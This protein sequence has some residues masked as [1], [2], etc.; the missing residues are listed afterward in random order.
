MDQSSPVENYEIDSTQ[1]Y[2]NRNLNSFSRSAPRVNQNRNEYFCDDRPA[3]NRER[4]QQPNADLD[5]LLN[6]IDDVDSVLSERRHRPNRLLREK[7]ICE[8]FRRWS[9]TFSGDSSEDPIGF[10]TD[11]ESCMR[12]SGIEE[13]EVLLYL[14]TIF[15]KQAKVWYQIDGD[16]WPSFLIFKN[17]FRNRFVGHARGV[18]LL[19]EITNRIQGPDEEVGEFLE[20][21]RLLVS[22]SGLRIAAGDV[23]DQA[24]GN[25]RQEYQ[26]HINRTA[27]QSFEELLE[28]C[29]YED[30]R[31]NKAKLNRIPQK[32]ETCHF[33]ALAWRPTKP[34][35][36]RKAAPIAVDLE[37]VEED[38]DDAQEESSAIRQNPGYNR[39]SNNNSKSKPNSATNNSQENDLCRE[40][41]KLNNLMVQII[42]MQDKPKYNKQSDNKAD[43]KCWK[44]DKS[45]H[46]AAE[47]PENKHSEKEEI[48]CYK[49]KKPGYTTVNCPNCQE[50]RQEGTH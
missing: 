2:E 15:T 18:S 27:F 9:L 6:E 41:K 17:R 16:N 26:V 12:R 49:C 46:F 39:S 36:N 32:P 5:Y 22:R 3:P 48:F 11:L 35:M 43:F 14:P 20:K 7:Q 29:R 44:C 38:L 50:N 45:R 4:A 8:A 30:Q 40:I 24:Y 25:L 42:K 47:C 34:L 33:P 28:L 31:R 1:W 23:L 37:E 10:L 19:G 21:F 13:N